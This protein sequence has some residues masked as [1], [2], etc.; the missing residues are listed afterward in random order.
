MIRAK[1]NYSKRAKINCNLKDVINDSLSELEFFLNYLKN[2]IPD[3]L[4]ILIEKLILEYEKGIDYGIVIDADYEI[5]SLHPELLKRS[6]NQILS[7]VEYNKYNKHSI[8]DLIDIDALDLVRASNLFEFSFKSSLLKIM[9]YKEVIEFIKQFSDDVVH[10]RKNP[11]K[12]VD[13]LEELLDRY[14]SGAEQWQMQ[15]TVAKIINDEKMLYKVSRCKWAEV[16]KDFDL[17]FCYSMMCYQDFENAKNQNPN[18]ILT[19]TK[20]ILMG[21]DYC[22]FCYHDTRNDKDIAH[23]SE[24]DFQELG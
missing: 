19:R 22:D 7:L 3:S 2:K 11:D 9:P 12:F 17:K 14:K 6:I 21:D 15:S 4:H 18:F 10:S 1:F 8:D 5:L 23:P 13:S 20:T 24:K 16:L